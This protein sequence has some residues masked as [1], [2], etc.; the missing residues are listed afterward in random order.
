M[1][2]VTGRGDR[3]LPHRKLLQAHPE[4]WTLDQVVAGEPSHCPLP[5]CHA[6]WPRPRHRCQEP[7]ATP[8]CSRREVSPFSHSLVITSQGFQFALGPF[9]L[10]EAVSGW[11]Q[12]ICRELFWDEQPPRAQGMPFFRPVPSP[13]CPAEAGGLWGACG[14]LAPLEVRSGKWG[15]LWA[16][17]GA[18]AP[19]GKGLLVP[20]APCPGG[21]ESVLGPL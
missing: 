7:L 5:S 4:S 16:V 6:L 9:S 1:R 8:T 3:P 18:P 19:Q 21:C 11:F 12:E 17:G 10:W 2:T 20:K 14:S 15:Q 13:P